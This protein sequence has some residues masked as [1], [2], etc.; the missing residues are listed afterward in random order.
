MVILKIF[1]LNCFAL[2]YTIDSTN[3]VRLRMKKEAGR[4]GHSKYRH[5]TCT[6]SS[7]HRTI[8]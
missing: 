7:L 5:K 6:L 3:S 2:S 4:A 1:S 8:V